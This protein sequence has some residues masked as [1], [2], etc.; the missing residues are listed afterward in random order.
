MDIACSRSSINSCLMI[1][2]FEIISSGSQQNRKKIK[3]ILYKISLSHST[4]PNLLESVDR[5]CCEISDEER[6][7]FLYVVGL[8]I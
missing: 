6:L 5:M 1:I 7:S 2:F 8:T 4:F 3:R